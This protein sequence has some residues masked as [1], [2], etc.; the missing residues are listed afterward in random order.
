MVRK[1]EKLASAR[2]ADEKVSLGSNEGIS[3]GNSLKRDTT[4]GLKEEKSSKKARKS[5]ADL[6]CTEE[7]KDE[8]EESD[9]ASEDESNEE[10][11]LDEVMGKC[12]S[13]AA[14]MRKELSHVL[15]KCGLGSDVM[16]QPKFISPELKMA[17]HQ[18]CHC[19]CF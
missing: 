11:V 5:V 1:R 6:S 15:L 13:M 19:H 8:I 9:A 16:Q 14:K 4:R 18:A 10:N 12:D 3:P 2:A 7:E 17:P